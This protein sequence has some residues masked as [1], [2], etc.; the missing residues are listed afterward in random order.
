MAKT[1]NEHGNGVKVL[2]S[3]SSKKYPCINK[4]FWWF[5]FFLIWI[6]FLCP[7][8]NYYTSAFLLGN[9][10]INIL[11]N[12]ASLTSCCT[13]IRSFTKLYKITRILFLETAVKAKMLTS[14]LPTEKRWVVS[15][16][17]FFSNTGTYLGNHS[18][19]E[20]NETL[21]I[22]LMQRYRFY[23]ARTG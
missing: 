10:K 19:L 15:F 12:Q 8:W 2:S 14:M 3:F 4:K 5:S 16:W 7:K 6:T 20:K 17:T 18:E 22:L 13:Y 23:K 1:E 21:K 9:T 11:T